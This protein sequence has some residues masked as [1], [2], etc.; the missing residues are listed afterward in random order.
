MLRDAVLRGDEGAWRMIYGRNAHALYAWVHARSRNQPDLAADVVQES[1]LIAVRRIRRFDPSRGTFQSWL[2]G[3][4]RNVLRNEWRRRE[5]LEPKVADCDRLAHSGAESEASAEDNRRAV[6][7]RLRRALAELSPRYQG[8][9]REKYAEGH[10]VAD[11]SSR[12]GA[13]AKAVESLLSRAREALR[14]AYAA[15]VAE[16]EPR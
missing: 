11:I 15:V 7:E 1:W 12:Y 5:R 6:I 10:S 9:L 16:E 13:S 3:I 14:S 8:V 4:A 2:R